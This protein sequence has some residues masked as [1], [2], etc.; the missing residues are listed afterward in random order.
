MRIACGMVTSREMPGL[1]AVKTACGMVTQL[2]RDIHEDSLR[3]GHVIAP[4][5]RGVRSWHGRFTGKPHVSMHHCSHS[6]LYQTIV[7][8][9]HGQQGHTT[10]EAKTA[11]CFCKKFGMCAG[12][13]H[14][15][16]LSGWTCFLEDVC[17]SA[18]CCSGR[19]GPCLAVL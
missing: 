5:N 6:C 17:N 19:S 8:D 18:W 14:F 9:D 15:V 7:K 3:H 4:G 10:G 11:V 16:S 13:A 1:L 2:S 12:R